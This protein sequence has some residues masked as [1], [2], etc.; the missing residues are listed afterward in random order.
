VFLLRIAAI[1]RLV[2]SGGR[3]EVFGFRFFVADIEI[4][5]NYNSV[6]N[7]RLK[8]VELYAGIGRSIEP[9]RISKDCEVSL[10]VDNNTYARDTY[11]HN[12]PTIPFSLSDL[13]SMT[14]KDLLKQ[15]GGRI[16]VLLGCP[17]CQGYSDNGRRSPYDPRNA[18][19]SKFVNFVID[20]KPMAVGMENVPLA[21]LSGRFELFVKKIEEAGYK[22]TATIANAALWGSC[23]S[24]QRLVFIAIR[25]DLKV[26]PKFP[27]PTHALRGKYFS[28]RHMR[29]CNPTEDLGGMLGLTP[30]SLQVRKFLPVQ[31][32]DD[33]GTN[34]TP[35]VGDIIGDLES[36]S[37]DK[38]KQLN[39]TPWMHT[40][41]TLRRMSSISEGGRWTG[42]ESY[43]SQTYGRLH[44]KGLARTITNYFANPGSGRFWHPTENRTLTTRE[45]ARI[46]GIPDSFL[47][48]R[49][50]SENCVL[51]GN[52]LDSS[53]AKLTYK[54]IRNG[55]G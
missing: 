49:P 27:R 2:V 16:D 8:V 45:A 43:F 19:I 40:P 50:T 41:K 12:F 48:P 30:A 1:I 46:Q 24:R 28:Y 18:H 53:I 25:N 38:A 15:A 47:F 37:S 10:L 42:K 52:A 17:P 23:Q 31:C 22:W 20:I 55:I 32:V 7:R 36:L 39:H 21:A 14:S 6:V 26:Q 35:V 44:R 9:F 4:Y 34:R 51:V 11:L 13:S 54:T 33:R 3:K 5:P 29:M